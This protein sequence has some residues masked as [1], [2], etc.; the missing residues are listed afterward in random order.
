MCTDCEVHNT[1]KGTKEARKQAE[2]D[3]GSSAEEESNQEDQNKGEAEYLGHCHCSL[4][5]VTDK[6]AGYFNAALL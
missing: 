2:K 1:K 6:M 3:N 5:K 4:F